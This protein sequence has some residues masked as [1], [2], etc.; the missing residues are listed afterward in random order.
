MLARWFGG[1]GRKKM[2]SLHTLNG[3]PI[4]N[5]TAAPAP[6][7]VSLPN[8]TAVPRLHKAE[9]GD[10]GVVGEVGELGTNAK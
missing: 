4:G 8:P 6:P 1:V 5:P 2:D 7:V 3:Q 9:A 10:V